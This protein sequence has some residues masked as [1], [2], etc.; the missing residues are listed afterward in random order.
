M[1]EWIKI[2]EPLAK[3]N[4]NATK[5][6]RKRKVDPRQPLIMNFFTVQRNEA[7]PKNTRTYTRRPPRPNQDEE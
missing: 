6:K 5:I 1:R 3:I 4:K 2:A 7:V